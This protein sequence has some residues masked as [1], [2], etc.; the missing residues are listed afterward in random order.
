MDTI[1]ALVGP[2]GRR[3][4]VWVCA[5]RVCAGALPSAH[6]C[7][8]V[9]S[10]VLCHDSRHVGPHHAPLSDARRGTT[11][12]ILPGTARACTLACTARLGYCSVSASARE[13]RLE[14]GPRGDRTDRQ[15]GRRVSLCAVIPLRTSLILIA[16]MVVGTAVGDG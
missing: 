10:V 11:S 2:L 7:L 15:C 1:Y 6:G 16:E 12:E 8:R 13:A 3:V 5:C 14:E 4:W 9:S